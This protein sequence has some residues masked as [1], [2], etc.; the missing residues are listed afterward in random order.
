MDNIRKIRTVLA[1]VSR[2]EVKAIL[3]DDKVDFVFRRTAAV[4]ATDV[5]VRV[6]VEHSFTYEQID[7]W[8]NTNRAAS[9]GKTVCAELDQ[10]VKEQEQG[11]NE[12]TC[13]EYALNSRG[14]NHNGQCPNYVVK[15]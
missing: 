7:S 6:E 9:L 8:P 12:S 14:W 1:A 2:S 10:K 4:V 15:Y 11:K 3:H 13:C 5:R